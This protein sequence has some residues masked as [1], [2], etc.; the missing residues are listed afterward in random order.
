MQVIIKTGASIARCTM[1][2]VL[3]TA[4]TFPATA[5][6]NPVSQRNAAF[7]PSASGGGDS[8]LPIISADGR[9]VLFASTA[10]NLAFVGNSSPLPRSLN[11]IMRDRTNGT[12]VLV[13]VNLPGTGGG[14][15]DSLPVGVSANGQFVLFESFATNLTADDA[16][17]V[18]DVFVRDLVNGTNILVSV[19]TNG[20]SGNGASRSAVITPDGRYVAFVSAANNLVPDDTNKIPDVFVRDLQTATTALASVGATSTNAAAAAP[21]GSSESPVI[22]PDGRYIAFF[23]T[24]TNLVPGVRF[25]GDVYVRD[26]VAGTTAWA[27]VNAR[28]IF[29]ANV[30]NSN[31]IACNHRISDDGQYVAFVA[32]TNRITSTSARGVALRHNLLSG[33]T[34]IVHTNAHMPLLPFEEIH[35]LDM[36]P[37]GRFIAF[38]ANVT[39]FSGS[40]SAVYLWDAQTG[41]NTLVSAS[42]NGAVVPNAISDSPAVSA[43]GQFVAFLSSA[44]N[45]TTNALAGGYHLYRRDLLAA[46]TRLVDADLNGVGAGVS[47]TAIPNMSADGRIVVFDSLDANLA[48]DDLNRSS[49]V[50][51]R[52]TV[53]DVTELISVRH[54]SLPSVTPNGISGTFLYSLNANGRYVAFASEADDLVTND[55]N[56]LRDVFVRDL[57]TGSNILVSVGTNGFSAAGM[58]TEPSISGDGRYVAFSGFATN[59]TANDANI[60]EDVFIRDLLAGTT[61]LVSVSTNGVNPGNRDSYLPTLGADGRYV[62]YRS[63]ASNLASGSFGSSVENLFLRDRQLGTNYAL[64]TGGLTNVAMTPDGRFVAY[65]DV[66]GSGLGRVYVWNTQ[67]ATRSTNTSTVGIITVAISPDGGKIA[68]LSG[69]SLRVVNRVGNTSVLVATGSLSPRLG[70]QFSGDGRFLTYALATGQVYLYDGQSNTS[71]LVSKAYNSTSGG[72]GVSDSSAISADGRFVTFRS[73]ATNIVAGDT[74]GFPDLFVYDRL[75]GTNSL[76]TESRLGSRSADNRSRTPVFSSNGRA[77]VFQSAASDLGAGDF[78]QLSDLFAFEFLYVDILPASSPPGGKVLSWPAAPGDNFLVQYKN[79]VNDLTWQDLAGTVNIIG[80]RA[81]LTNAPPVPDQRFYRVVAQ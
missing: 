52:D 53:S 20:N 22:T 67:L 50:F 54:S 29:F 65:V 28:S 60:T 16:N 56:N 40:D 68:T 66:A 35:N 41:L 12:T 77:I 18:G 49:D 13:S 44:A 21:G 8:G 74:N 63:K 64:T 6:L 33:I 39:G 69:T 81:Y 47:S 45:L 2:A 79:N 78:N 70:L 72:N 30:G 76:L 11:V 23:S 42:T 7:P 14:N 71:L 9:Y 3:V 24:A 48:L 19:S 57:V 51:A 58:S 25:V 32:S 10:G 5:A 38:A 31:T 59:I 26:A 75:A 27:S 36:T 46:S 62:L 34:D 15:G 17:N 73:A 55:A 4:I 80:N 43:N 37:N 1:L 61:T